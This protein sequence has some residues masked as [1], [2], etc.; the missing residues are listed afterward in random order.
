MI[1][2]NLYTK[3]IYTKQLP[4]GRKEGWIRTLGLMLHISVYKIDNKQGTTTI[5][6]S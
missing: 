4:K 2:M 6:H 3:Q 5:S 1:Q